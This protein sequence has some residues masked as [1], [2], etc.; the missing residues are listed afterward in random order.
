MNFF[1]VIVVVVVLKQSLTLSPRLNNGAISAHCNFCLPAS[2]DST[3]ASW[4][5]GITGMCHHI[6]LSLRILIQTGFLHVDQ[7]GLELPTSSHPPASASQRAGITDESRHMNE[8]VNSHFK[9][10]FPS[11]NKFKMTSKYSVKLSDAA[12]FVLPH[13]V[14]IAA[15]WHGYYY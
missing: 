5:P 8:Q 3:S 10:K 11:K 14:L 4:V 15:L 6:W 7:P 12:Y 13:L 9:F 1:F 2:S